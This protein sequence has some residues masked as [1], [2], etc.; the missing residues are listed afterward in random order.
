[1]TL[2]LRI[3]PSPM[4]F[5]Y[6]PAL[7]TVGGGFR[8]VKQHCRIPNSGVATKTGFCSGGGALDLRKRIDSC[9]VR[10]SLE[11]VN[12]SVGEVTEVDKETF[13]PIVKA[14]GDKIVVLDMYTQW[15]V[16]ITSSCCLFEF[17]FT[18]DCNLYCFSCPSRK[19]LS[20]YFTCHI[21]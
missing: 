4:S 10:C 7:T 9:V 21:E 19:M 17:R 11:T 12:V 6:P 20:L 5:Y 2:S 8:P 1:M 18:V 13:W 15:Y 3:A 14:A 16:S